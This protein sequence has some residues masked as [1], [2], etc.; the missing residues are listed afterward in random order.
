MEKDISSEDIQQ[1]LSSYDVGDLVSFERIKGGLAN[2]NYKLKTTENIFLLKINDE[3]PIQDLESQVRVLNYLKSHNYPSCFP[4][5]TKEGKF[6]HVQGDLK[7]VIYNF[8]QGTPGNAAALTN[9]QGNQ[10][11]TTL[12][13][14]HKISPL[15]DIPEYALGFPSMEAMLSDLNGSDLQKNPF[16]SFM[17]Q[18]M[19]NLAPHV[20]KPFDCGMLHGDLFADNM[21]FD[22]K[23][24]LQAVVDFEEICNGPLILDLAMTVIGCCYPQ[25]N[26]LNVPLATAIVLSYD[27]ERPLSSQEKESLG[28]F[29]KFSLLSIAFWRFRQFNVRFPGHP[30]ANRH[31]ELVEKLL[32]FPENLVETIFNH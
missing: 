19:S 24:N 23:G 14:L 15:K 17:T 9:H 12:A 18:Q 27:S 26:D 13:K 10:I 5:P 30:A 31:Q 2:R 28:A 29:V 21:I 3:K 4:F 20:N 25:T 22:Q 8:I 1:I 6:Y 16:I 11:G 32:V 7:V